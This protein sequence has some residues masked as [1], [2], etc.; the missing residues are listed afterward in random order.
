MFRAA[1]ENP[2]RGNEQP[3]G[4]LYTFCG[5]YHPI[6]GVHNVGSSCQYNTIYDFNSSANYSLES[7]PEVESAPQ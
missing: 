4:E 6:A 2:P 1:L 3:D 7:D 5:G